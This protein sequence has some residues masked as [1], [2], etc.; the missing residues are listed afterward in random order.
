MARWPQSVL[1]RRSTAVLALLLV[2]APLLLAPAALAQATKNAKGGQRG[3]IILTNLPPRGS[4]AYNALL[5]LAGK[6]ARGEIL[7]LSKAE[8]WQMPEDRISEVMRSGAA[9][10]VKITK[11]GAD[12]NQVLKAP[13]APMKM[14]SAQESMMNSMKGAKES[15]AVGMMMAPDPALIEYA[16]MKDSDVTKPIGPRAT[17]ALPPKIMIPISGGVTIEAVRTSVDLKPNGC[18]WRGTI[19]GT[20]EPVMLMWWK[21]G[22]FSGMFTHR[23]RNYTVQNMGGEVHAVVE[24]DP[25]KMPPDHGTMHAKTQGNAD[26]KDALVTTGEGDMMRDR[27][28]LKD[29][30]DALGGASPLGG[31]KPKDLAP[32]KIEPISLAK[33]HALAA[34]PITIDLMVLYTNR[35]ATKYIDVEKDLVALAVEQ[36]NESFVTSGIGNIKLR[37][38]HTEKIG[39]DESD[40]EYFDHLYRMVDGKPGFET[41]RRLRNEKRADVVALIIDDVSGCGLSTRV[42]ADAD[43]AFVVVHHSCAV[44]TYSMAHEIGHILGARHDKALDDNTSPFPYGHGFVNGTKWRDIMSYTSSCNGCPRL[45]FW[46]NPTIKVMG[47]PG[48]T[49]DTDNARVI[50][51]QADRVSKFR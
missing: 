38:V 28:N 37:L 18:T 2:G 3:E 25:N 30:Q 41:V 4:K 5:G 29:K 36:T 45:P 32:V 17:G 19:E 10:G 22:R 33:R 13:S 39:Y 24:T 44:L 43:E 40:G 9:K 34:K 7:T 47:E 23:G 6:T 8:M 31:A 21:D 26:L 1:A 49:N 14:T 48:G 12:Y 46:S 51:E 50:L 42:A 27:K 20:G 35:V 16:L 11:L 15:M